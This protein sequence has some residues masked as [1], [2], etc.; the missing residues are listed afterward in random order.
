MVRRSQFWGTISKRSIEDGGRFL[1]AV[2]SFQRTYPLRRVPPCAN[3]DR[4][5]G[6]PL[7]VVDDP[8]SG[9]DKRRRR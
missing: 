6:C 4:V 8:P 1:N 3:P 7:M 2:H 5:R 9:T